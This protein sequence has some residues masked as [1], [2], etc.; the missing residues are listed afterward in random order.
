MRIKS[1]RLHLTCGT[2]K[3]LRLPKPMGILDA[4]HKIREIVDPETIAMAEI[5]NNH[6]Q[7][8][9]ETGVCIRGL[10]AKH[11]KV[12]G[13]METGIIH[14][15]RVQESMRK[16]REKTAQ[17]KRRDTHGDAV[18]ASDSSASSLSDD[19]STSPLEPKPSKQQAMQETVSPSASSFF[20]W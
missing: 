3:E 2:V 15:R 14:S 4:I 16:M 10:I 17:F 5:F 8:K 20:S 1:C 19:G 18:V 11:T 9:M 13:F 6:G 7:V 12:E